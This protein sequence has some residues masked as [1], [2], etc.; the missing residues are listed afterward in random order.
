MHSR[1]PKALPYYLAHDKNVFLFSLSN[2]ESCSY[3]FCQKFE[4]FGGFFRRGSDRNLT[5]LEYN[6][7]YAR[8]NKVPFL[9]N[10]YG[11][12]IVIMRCL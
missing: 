3:V 4:T 7:V 8:V 5:K 6:K 11:L 9:Y 1:W 12:R 2:L 10:Q